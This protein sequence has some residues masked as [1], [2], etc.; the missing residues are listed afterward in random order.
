MAEPHIS[1][2]PQNLSPVEEKLRG[3]LEDQLSSALQAATGKIEHDYAGE[4]VD[5]VTGMLLQRTKDGLHPDI[6]EGFQPDPNQLRQVA[7]AI[8]ERQ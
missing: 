1:L 8:V 4:S 5:Q 7:E 3:P 2:D 6:A